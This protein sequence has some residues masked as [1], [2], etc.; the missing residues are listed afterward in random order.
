MDSTRL[1]PY[2]HLLWRGIGAILAFAVPV[3]GAL[4]YL[5]IPDGPWIVVLACEAAALLLLALAVYRYLRI[6]IWVDAAGIAE[7]GFFFSHPRIP[8]AQLGSIVSAS[9]FPSGGVDT[10]HQLF[11]RGLDGRQ[12][13][14]LRGQ[15]WS[16]EA[17]ATVI[18]T[19]DVPLVE[20][21]YPISHRDL[22]ARYPGLLYWFERRPV[23]ATSLF[24]GLL[25]L[26]GLAL[27]SVLLLLGMAI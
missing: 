21:D 10:V 24:A 13:V 14:R 16:R 19:L 6:G 25:V 3:F 2:R 27:Y 8:L 11:V 7:R 26:G 1:R 4:L 22:E 20:I 5:T 15:F 17:M 18:A 9:T 23:L 12:R